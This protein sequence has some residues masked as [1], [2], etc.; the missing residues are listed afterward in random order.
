MH[1]PTTVSIFLDY[2]CN[3][4]CNHCSVGSSPE[5]EFRMPDDVLEQAFEEVEKIDPEVLVFTG[6]EVTLQKERLLES[7]RRADEMGLHTRIV[8]N[9]WWARDMKSAREMIGELTDAGLNELNTSYDD[10]HTDFMGPEP[11]VNLIEAGL[12]SDL[13]DILLACIVGHEDPE[14]DRE[15]IKEL[16]N[17][18]LDEPVSEQPRLSMIEDS[19]AP[20]GSGAQLDVSNV[21]A[22]NKVDG[23]CNEVVSTVSIHPDASVKACCGHAQWY[24]PDLTLGNIM[25]EPLLEILDRSKRNLV[26]WLI[27]EVGPK[28]MIERL[29]P[30][31]DVHYSGICH[32][33]HHLLDEYREE[34]LEYVEENREDIIKNDIILSDSMQRRADDLLE[35]KEDVLEKVARLKGEADDGEGPGRVVS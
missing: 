32:A 25:D 22:R 19:A 29:D 17:E 5:T 6:G 8:S 15:R 3:F 33:C 23:G 7:L 30:E 28:Q 27:H 34:L 1:K 20:M 14:Y 10:F 16:V 18:R 21:P 35:N 31:N 24:V 9:G 26:Y 13:D 4:A 11:I 12:E 2:K